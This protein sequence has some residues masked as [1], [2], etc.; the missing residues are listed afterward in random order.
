MKA[1]DS[2]SL[3]HQ[4]PIDSHQKGGCK[5][6]VDVRVAHTLVHES[7]NL[8]AILFLGPA[9]EGAPSVD[10][11]CSSKALHKRLQAIHPVCN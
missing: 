8:I 2:D 6:P 3:A 5:R 7:P 4:V 9:T 11:C 1:S 10:C